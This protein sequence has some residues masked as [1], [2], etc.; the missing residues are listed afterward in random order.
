MAKVTD[1]FTATRPVRSFEDIVRQIHDVIQSGEALPGDRLASERELCR[2]FGVSRPTLREALRHLEA[3]GSVQVQSGAAGGIFVAT[4]GHE[5]A[6]DALDVLVRFYDVTARDLKEFRP[7]FESETAMWASRRADAQDLVN[8]HAILQELEEAITS[9]GVPWHVISA[10]DLRFHEAVTQAS[11][12]RLRI[13]IMGAVFRAVQ[14]ASLSLADV[15]DA[16]AR[17]SI[18]VELRGIA[19][20]IEA[21]DEVLSAELMARHVERFSSIESEVEEGAGARTGGGSQ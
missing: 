3:Q 14:R 13:A 16:T 12:N 10:L 2:V 11:K 5:Q 19:D 8:L 15:F 7:A 18:L 20:A 17:K 4:P 21:R 9:P 1:L 6:T